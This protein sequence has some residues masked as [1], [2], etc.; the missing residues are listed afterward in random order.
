MHLKSYEC[1]PSYIT[2]WISLNLGQRFVLACDNAS[3]DKKQEF[4]PSIQ[5][6]WVIGRSGQ[7]TA[8]NR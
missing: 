4:L 8:E 3:L 2:K 6:L 1:D 5:Q 7:V